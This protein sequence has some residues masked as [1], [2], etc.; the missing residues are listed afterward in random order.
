MPPSAVAISG[1]P[2]V[3]VVNE[4]VVKTNTNKLSELGKMFRVFYKF[5]IPGNGTIYIRME[6]TGDAIRN[7]RIIDLTYGNIEYTSY[8]NSVVSGGTLIPTVS[9]LNDKFPLETPNIKFYSTPD[10]STIGNMSDFVALKTDSVS[11]RSVSSS[12]P[13]E[14]QRYYS[15]KTFLLEIKNLDNNIASGVFRFEFG[16]LT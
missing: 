5:T 7:G 12:S 10:V 8:Y 15:A 6:V 3:K 14:S 16:N 11:S 13:T 4:P 2:E 1:Q 9:N